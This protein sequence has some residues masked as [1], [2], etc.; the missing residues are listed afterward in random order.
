M[1]IIAGIDE[2]GY[3][4]LL[5]PL[6]VTGVVFEVPDDQ[7]DACL[8]ELLS[9]SVTRRP[10]RKDL[11]LPVL[12]SKKLHARGKGIESL[13][14]T[15]LGMLQSSLP[16]PDSFAGLL[17]RVAPHALQD[18]QNYPWYAD[19][20]LDLPVEADSGVVA[21]QANAVRR[22]ARAAGV[23]LAAVISEPLLEGHYNRLVSNTRN[24]AVVL[25]GLTLRIVQRIIERAAGAPVRVYADRQGG[26]CRYLDPLMRAF[27]G[28][29]FQILE[30]SDGRSAY[31]LT[32]SPA[33]HDIEFCTSGEDK[34]L[35]TAL[36][37]VFSKYLRE[38]FMRG[39]NQYWSGRVNALRP[40]AGYYTDAQR[41]LKD[42]AQAVSKEGIDRA[43]LVRMR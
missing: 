9:Q 17:Q 16:A 11:R 12:D 20:K 19:L 34:H 25:M 22:N 35:P 40:T 4:P 10:T 14:R 29:E 26:R 33:R 6:V 7:A 43:Q 39:F 38:L 30:E 1:A 37:S 42:I 18:M 21:T 13:E 27:E 36:A 2:A 15:A 3:G 28:F 41:F 23:R 8:W 24:K 31:R 5:G 32:R